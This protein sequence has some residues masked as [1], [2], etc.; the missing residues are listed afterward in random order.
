MM[1]QWKKD[2]LEIKKYTTRQ[3]M[4]A[5]AAADVE[6]VIAQLIQEKGHINMIF[7]AAPSQ[8]G[9]QPRIPSQAV[10][11]K[12]A[13]PPMVIRLFCERA[14]KRCV[15]VGK[16]SKKYTKIKIYKSLPHKLVNV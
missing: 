8:N 13:V 1:E 6:R 16:N 4:G 2:Q 12:T 5:G 11:S 9:S 10:E 7:A 14:V 15:K 3:E